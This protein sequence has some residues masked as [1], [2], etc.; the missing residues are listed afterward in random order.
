ML[1]KHKSKSG[2]QNVVMWC[3]EYQATDKVMKVSDIKNNM[4]QDN[5]DINSLLI[6]HET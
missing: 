1:P 4:F 5:S 2:I 6:L 3:L